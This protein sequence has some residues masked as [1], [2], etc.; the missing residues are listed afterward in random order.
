M[1]INGY[2]QPTFGATVRLGPL[3]VGTSNGFNLLFASNIY[4][5]NAY[6]A[7]KVPILYKSPLKRKKDSCPAF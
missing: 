1:G 5:I 4:G 6:A 3:I 2:G 7:L